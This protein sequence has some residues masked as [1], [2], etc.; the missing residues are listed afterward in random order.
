MKTIY[1]LVALT[2]SMACKAQIEK[3]SLQASGLTCSMCSNAIN[4]ALKKLDF[5]QRVDANVKNYTFEIY[6]KDENA[7]DFDKIRRKVEGAGF[8]VSGFTVSVRFDQVPLEP[9]KQ[10]T[11]G[12]NK[13]ILTNVTSSSLDGVTQIKLLDKGF[14]PE[15]D[16]NRFSFE[17][18][19]IEAIY[20][21]AI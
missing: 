14:V 3:V 9:T 11:L 4:K 17:P 21:A 6:F 1:L 12:K 8:T 20:H 7:I 5:V 19:P 16:E 13:V 2:L 15:Q 18:S 10:I